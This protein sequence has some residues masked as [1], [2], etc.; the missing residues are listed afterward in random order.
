[1]HGKGDYP[2]DVLDMLVWRFDVTLSVSIRAFEV[3]E[4]RGSQSVGLA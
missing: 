1:M 4:S 2:A 3:V